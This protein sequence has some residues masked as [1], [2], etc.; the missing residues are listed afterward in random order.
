MKIIQELQVEP[1]DV[2]RR[3]NQ[4]IQLQQ[5]REEVHNK[6]QVIQENVKKKFDRR[7]KADDFNI[8]DKVL[9][10]D[11]RREDKGKNGKFDNLWKGPYIIHDF[12]GN[13]AFFLKDLDGAELPGGPVN[14]RMLKHY[15]SQHKEFL[16]HHCK[17]H[18]IY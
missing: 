14:G 5:S 6:T 17:Y 9:R 2:Q 3:I 7:T 12:R 4:T 8:R 15:F 11:A 18:S 13:N 10:W 16:L 1:N